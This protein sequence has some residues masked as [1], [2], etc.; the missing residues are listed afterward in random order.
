MVRAAQ[1]TVICVAILLAAAFLGGFAGR[2]HA[3][4]DSLAVF[5]VPIAILFGLVAIWSPWPAAMRWSIAVICIAAMAQV[6]AQKY[7]SHPPGPILV[8]QKNLLF[9]N[10]QVAALEADIEAANPDIIALQELTSRNASLVQNLRRA[11]PHQASCAL[12][13]WA[14]VAVLSRWPVDGEICVEN[15]GLVGV[16][17]ISPDG[18]FW[19]FSL[20]AS[21]PWPYGQAAQ[22]RDLL[23]VLA[24]LDDPI[25]L[26]GD[27]NMVP[28]SHALRQVAAITDT[29]RAGPLFPTFRKMGA[30]LPIDH[31]YAP[32]GGRAGIRPLAGSDHFGVLAEV[33]VFE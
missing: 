25:V 22:W 20:H 7:T 33:V 19:A 9:E 29:S 31:V 30:P 4:G 18:A 26:A 3:A 13:S 32:E 21:W 15:R 23:P 2:W 12:T 14:R 8:Y 28:W 16:R 1:W 11:Y 6:V 10:D 24:S 27:F 17:V 5:R